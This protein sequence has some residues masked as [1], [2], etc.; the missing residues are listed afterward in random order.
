MV[1]AKK[2]KFTSS[3]VNNFIRLCFL[4]KKWFQLSN[5]LKDEIIVKLFISLKWDE[6]NEVMEIFN[7]VY[8]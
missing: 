4:I 8:E 6:I 7:Y 2:Y 5:V 3:K 1:D